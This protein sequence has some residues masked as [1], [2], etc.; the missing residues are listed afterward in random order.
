[1]EVHSLTKLREIF[2][3]GDLIYERGKTILID[4]HS[5]IKTFFLALE[6]LSEQK[7]KKKRKIVMGLKD[8]HSSVFHSDYVFESINSQPFN[9]K[10]L[11][12]KEELSKLKEKRM[13]LLQELESC[14]EKVLLIYKKLKM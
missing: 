8:M 3:A 2:N 14:E 9:Y 6:K 10:K 12:V 7:N 1:M 11:K 5:T 4:T 13:N